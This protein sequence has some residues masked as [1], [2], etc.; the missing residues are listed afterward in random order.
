MRTLGDMRRDG[1]PTGR[2]IP[3]FVD[4]SAAVAGLRLTKP[5]T[6]R[7][8]RV[9]VC[10]ASLKT[11]CTTYL[12]HHFTAGFCELHDDIFRICDEP[13]PLTGKRKARVAP[14]KFGKS[15]IISMAKPLHDLAY[16]RRHFVLLIGESASVAE[17]NL[18]TLTQELENNE[19]LLEDFPH[20]APA[21][22][23]K[24]QLVKWTDSQV[25]LRSMD[26]V[27]A[28][29]MGARMRGIK[30]RQMRPD[31]AILDDPESP[32]TADTFLKRRRHKRWFGGTFMG[33]G[34][35]SWDVYVIGNL[36]HHDCLI[37]SLVNDPTWD[38]KLYRAINLPKRED[39]RYP[40]GN[41][42][43]DG[44]PLW[45]EMWG[46]K[47]LDAFKAEPN[48]GSLGFVREMLNDPR[49]EEDK[50]FNPQEFTYVDVNPD[51]G[52]SDYRDLVIAVDPAGGEKPGEMRRGVRDWCVIGLLGRHTEGSIDVL[53]ITMTR[54][55][56]EKQIDLLLNMYDRYRP[57][58]I[59]AEENMWKNLYGPSIQASATRRSLYPTLDMFMSKT[60]KLARIQGI[61]PLIHPVT[62]GTST[63]RFAKYLID[64]V[65]EY[66]GQ[67]DEFP[68]GHDD[69]PDMTE[70]GIRALESGGLIR[71]PSGITSGG[72]YWRGHA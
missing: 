28:R 71:A 60:N 66:F 61:Q 52:L 2:V 45:P 35:E 26:T 27:M 67:F 50:I 13:S 59:R 46:H 30:Y 42:R 4:M 15:T 65:P 43:F 21:R 70:M 9:E 29:G 41:T 7:S 56:P 55:T 23:T 37:S 39:E 3:G 54:A 40:V 25:T 24:G 62:G 49:E 32:E 10:R 19:M 48:V 34:A 6:I 38:G 44:T 63:V 14:R 11:F 1:G 47:R 36:P 58:R 33:L 17:S 5:A 53:A 18:A 12:G 20:L 68:T 64:K 16:Q 8:Q 57:R 31:L 69:G 72:S 22:D 51:L